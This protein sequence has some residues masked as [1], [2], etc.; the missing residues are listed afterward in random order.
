V[1]S[2]FF[3]TIWYGFPK[4]QKKSHRESHAKGG[5]SLTGA[6]L[7]EIVTR[8]KIDKMDAGTLPKPFVLFISGKMHKMI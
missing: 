7:A 4:S 1:S 2:R 8:E 3:K 6:S 5:L